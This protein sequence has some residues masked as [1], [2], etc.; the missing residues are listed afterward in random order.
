MDCHK[1]QAQLEFTTLGQEAAGSSD[2]VAAKTHLAE[3]DSCHQSFESQRRFDMRLSRAMSDVTIPAGLNERLSAAIGETF[4]QPTPAQPVRGRSL[5]WAGGAL[6]SVLLILWCCGILSPHPQKLNQ[7]NVHQLADMDLNALPADTRADLF[8]VPGEWDS[9]R[10]IRFGESPRLAKVAGMNL[11]V[12]PLLLQPDRRSPPVSG[13]VVQ[14]PLAKWHEVPEE[15][16]F[17][18]AP[19]QY[20]SFGTWVVWRE[21]DTVFICVVRDNAETLQ[22]MQEL[23]TASRQLT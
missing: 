7:A 23:V 10:G 19:M 14:L 3:C 22:R 17:A 16:S 8:S 1:A 5:R 13:F 4:S 18:A 20:A 21:G 11:T 12:M 2:L 15:S 6:A 9:L